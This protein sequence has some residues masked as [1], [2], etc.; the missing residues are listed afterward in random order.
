[1]SAGAA[2]RLLEQLRETPA[3][4]HHAHL[5]VGDDGVFALGDDAAPLYEL[6]LESP[7]PDRAR[8]HVR[9]HPSH[10]RA[11]RDLAGL[12]GVPAEEAAV[13]AARADLGHAAY[14]R[15]LFDESRLESLY[16]DDGLTW[17]GLMT[18]TEQQRV[19]G[20]PVRRIARVE[21]LVQDAAAG[22][23]PFD[24]V[25]A[26]FTAELDR[27]VAGGQLA[28]LKSIAAYRC[29]LDLPPADEAAARAGYDA[30]RA[31]GS[32]RLVDPHVVSWF[33]DR[34]LEVTADP[35]LPLQFHAGAVGTDVAL[36]AGDPAALR[37]WLNR[38]EHRGVPVVVLHCWPYL[39]EAS[40]LAGLFP[41]V[42]L[43]LSMAM[44]WVGSTRGAELVLEVLGVA[45]VSKLLFATDGFRVPEL[46]Y[47]GARW[48]RESLAD[49]LGG[50]V[51][52]GV[53]DEPTARGYGELVL[54]G[55]AHRI[56][57][58]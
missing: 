24:E 21:V 33:L 25:A 22:W 36:T 6:V 26:R 27:A 7:E 50:L 37:T 55:N 9:A 4:D 18:A 42:H 34:A 8:A 1:V 38:P 14:V 54:R 12:L 41:D 48:W 19:T 53:V 56:Y 31:G 39:R 40:W 49:A 3:V 5:L 10:A 43:D 30:W 28:A 23:P 13:A 57:G 2:P 52:R 44:Q 51:D 29:G 15:L 47:L 46:F 58:R 45:P 20:V 16:V 17:P 11:M 35:R 32:P